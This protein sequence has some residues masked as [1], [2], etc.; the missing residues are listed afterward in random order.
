MRIH[1]TNLTGMGSRRLLESLLPRLLEVSGDA[2]TVYLRAEDPLIGL[3]SEKGADV[4]TVR[5]FLPNAVSRLFEVTFGAK[6]YRGS[7]GIL[8]LGDI[9]LR[10]IERQTVLVHN[11]FMVDTAAAAGMFAQ[12]KMCA[13]QAIFAMNATSVETFIV[14]T[15]TMKEGLSRRYGISKD[16]IRIIGQPPPEQVRRMRGVLTPSPPPTDN[17]RLKLFYPSRLYPHKNHSLLDRAT[18]DLLAEDVSDIVLTI[19]PDALPVSDH[20]ILRCI[21]EVDLDRIVEEYKAADALLFLSLAESYGLPLIE[22]LWLD[23]PIICP[24]LPYARDLLEE[25]PYY[26]GA[27]SLDE[28][29]LSVRRLRKDL[30][31]GMKVDWSE[32][33]NYF[34][35]SW[36][37]VAR[38]FSSAMS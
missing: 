35:A 3:A 12:L 31:N 18:L 7:D 11:P 20:P 22:A 34:P 14:Q 16:R 24:D 10:G 17:R 5:R 1:A 2:K 37:E 32:R 30:T 15:D 36:Q 6:R 8:V 19:A 13:L 25:N 29:L 33:R 28:L 23:L 21:G 9:P 26:F 27:N 38:E 4:F